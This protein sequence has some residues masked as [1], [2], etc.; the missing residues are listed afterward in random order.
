[1]KFK[2]ELWPLFDDDG[3]FQTWRAEIKREVSNGGAQLIWSR[4]DP[5]RANVANAMQ[6]AIS[7]IKNRATDQKDKLAQRIEGEFEV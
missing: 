7:A 4:E 5:A 6:A 3:I 2:Y 1:M